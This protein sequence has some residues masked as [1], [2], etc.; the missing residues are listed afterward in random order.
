MDSFEQLEHMPGIKPVPLFIK[1][2][3]VGFFT[4]RE[5]QRVTAT[6]SNLG[7]IKTPAELDPWLR[8]FTAMSSTSTMFVCVSSWHDDLVL[9]ISSAYRGT[10]V[11]RR[12][13]G[14]MAKEGLDVTLYATEVDNG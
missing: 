4:W 13:L 3:T 9:G 10:G 1:N 14:G 2:K 8:G 7:A 6:L 12:F 11:L 5:N